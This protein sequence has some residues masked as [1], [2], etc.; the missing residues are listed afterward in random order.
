MIGVLSLAR[1]NVLWTS[2]YFSPKVDFTKLVFDTKTSKRVNA[3]LGSITSRF[4]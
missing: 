4:V 1:N 2:N 3:N